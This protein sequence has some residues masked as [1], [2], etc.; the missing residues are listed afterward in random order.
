MSNIHKHYLSPG[1]VSVLVEAITYVHEHGKNEF[2]LQEHLSLSHNAYCNA[3]KLRYWGLIAHLKGRRGYWVITKFGGMFLR[4][5][6]DMPEWV[7]TQDNH[8]VAK[9]MQRI[10]IRELRNKIPFVQQEFAYEVRDIIESRQQ[11]LIP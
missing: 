2:H 3:Q 5:E 6:I 1:L 7:E 4:G 10:H 11:L 9:S 8:R